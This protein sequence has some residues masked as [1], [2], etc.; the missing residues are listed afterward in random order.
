MA[1]FSFAFKML[2]PTYTIAFLF[3]WSFSRHPFFAAL[4]AA[5]ISIALF[6][7]VSVFH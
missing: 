7:L 4:L 1:R 6:C 5:V 3:C 2:F